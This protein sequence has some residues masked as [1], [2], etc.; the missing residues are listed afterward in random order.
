MARKYNIVNSNEQNQINKKE[1]RNVFYNLWI[2]K[3][4]TNKEFLPLFNLIDSYPLLSPIDYEFDICIRLIDKCIKDNASLE[5]Y[6][7]IVHNY[8]KGSYKHNFPSTKFYPI[9]LHIRAFIDNTVNK[10][11][12]KLNK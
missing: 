3:Y 6:S 1:V 7:L 5:T 4:I 11:Y 9:V 10:E 8:L 2:N 12:L